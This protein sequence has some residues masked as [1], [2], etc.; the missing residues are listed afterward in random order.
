M[1]RQIADDLGRQI[2]SGELPPGNRLPAELELRA[3]Y[4][5]SRNTVRDAVRWL[6]T[7]GLVETRPGQ[8]TFVT[9]EIVPFVTALTPSLEIGFGGEDGTYVMEVT[10]KRRIPEARIPRVE[11]Q[12]AADTGA[13][14]L[15]LAR[16]AMVISRHQQR[17]IDETPWSLQTSFYPRT[18]DERGAERLSVANDI[19]QGAVAYI[20]E[21]LSIKL[22]GWRDKITVRAPDEVETAFFKLPDDG[23]VAVIETRRTGFDENGSPFVLTVS[24]F[25]ADRNQFVIDV[26][27]VPPEVVNPAASSQDDASSPDVPSPDSI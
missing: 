11:I 18:L 27:Q 21:T 8:G 1:Y 4:D 13:V 22:M 16:D 19:A 23:R 10:A 25:P 7:R 6:I 9:A 12:Q 5:A 24:T 2:E 20:E 26:G 15:Q 17:Y 14:E 3:R